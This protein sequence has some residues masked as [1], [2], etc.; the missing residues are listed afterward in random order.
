MTNDLSPQRVTAQVRRA[1]FA[2]IDA[3]GRSR[4]EVCEALG[5]HGRPLSRSA[6][7]TR[8]TGQ[9]KFYA[10][11]L[12]MLAALLGVS[13]TALCEGDVHVRRRGNVVYWQ[14]GDARGS[15]DLDSVLHRPWEGVLLP[16]Q[17]RHADEHEHAG[18]AR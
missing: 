13:V 16:S 11:E 6:L 9:T 18:C 1:V 5:T 15:R 4:R 14:A 12:V 17:S 7:D 2:L 3:Q 8:R 10:H